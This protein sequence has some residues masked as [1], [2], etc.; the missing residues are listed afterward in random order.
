M[1]L[2]ISIPD[3]IMCLF[4]LITFERLMILM[5]KTYETLYDKKSQAL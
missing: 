3:A 1:T 5:M 4:F 2:S